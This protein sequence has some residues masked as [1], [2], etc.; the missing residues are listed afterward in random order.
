MPLS[1]SLSSLLGT[2]NC[3]TVTLSRD[4]LSRSLSVSSSRKI[5]LIATGL[6]RLK[7]A[8]NWP[9]TPRNVENLNALLFC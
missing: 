3:Y 7:I 5:G 2:G 9:L 6:T 4:A 1:S 8:E